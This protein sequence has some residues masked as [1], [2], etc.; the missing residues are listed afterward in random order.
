MTIVAEN[1]KKVQYNPF[2]Q[3]IAVGSRFSCGSH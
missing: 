2:Q 3:K 1:G